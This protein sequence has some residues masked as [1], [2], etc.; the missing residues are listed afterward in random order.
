MFSSDAEEIG[1]IVDKQTEACY[2]CH[3]ADPPLETLP[4]TPRSRVFRGPEEHRILGITTPIENEA[5]CVSASCHAHSQDQSVLGVLDVMVSLER[6][7]R[8][9]TLSRVRMAGLAVLT[10]L[11]SSAILWWLTRR[12]VVGPVQ[13]LAAGTQAVTEGDLT[14]QIEVRGNH[15]LGELG[16][17][18]NTMT[19][20]LA[21]AQ[22]QITQADKLASVGRLAAG[23]AHEINNPLTGVLTYASLLLKQADD[24]PQLRDDLEVIVRETKRCREIIKGLLD[25]SRQSRPQS[26]PTDINEAVRRAV[27]VVMN[28]LRLEQVALTLDLASDIAPVP[29]DANQIQQVVV[30]LLLNAMDAI[31]PSGGTVRVTTRQRELSPWG[32]AEIR[33]AVCAGGCDLLDRQVRI[34]GLPAIQVIRRHAHRDAVVHL[35]PVYGRFNHV[36]S[37]PCEELIETAFVCPGCRTSLDVENGRCPACGAGTFAVSVPGDGRV[38]WCRRAACHWSRWESRD[39]A[40]PQTTLEIEVQDS[41][42]GIST[43]ELSHVFE[44]FFSTKGTHGTGLGL[45]VSW[46]IVENHGGRIEVEST[47]G[48]GSRFTVRL[49]AVANGDVRFSTA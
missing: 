47:V 34:G 9:I 37:E 8:Q 29:A 44:P 48:E 35:D 6:E 16:R 31:G 49:P 15:E 5:S 24:R 2:G 19:R 1:Q 27:T 4:L 21:E 18:F 22:Q 43:E 28:Q 25:F 41:G 38:E 20:K 14:T 30:N 3:A 45:A 7:D 36:A 10:I 11:A 40:E 32:H 33:T 17:S 42:C 23:V 12:L 39:A 46:G 26:Q 13:A